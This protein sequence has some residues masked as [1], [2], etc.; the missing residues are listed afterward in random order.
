V[1]DTDQPPRRPD[2]IA[3][4]TGRRRIGV[5]GGSFDPIHEGH[6]R[7]AE[8][9]R[10][11]L[12]LE[13]VLLVPAGSQPL[14]GGHAPA[15]HRLAMVRLAV[16]GRDG[17]EVSDAEVA[18]PGTSYTVDTVRE[19]SKAL[20]AD[21]ELCLLIGTDA[22]RDLP[23]W[24]DVQEIFSHA[25]PVVL[26]RPGDGP[27]DW[28]DLAGRLTAGLAGRLRDSTVCL[29]RPVDVSS[30]EVRRRLAAGEPVSG[31]VPTAVEGYIRRHGLYG[32]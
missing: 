16:E 17:L 9:A 3:G 19:I 25:R 5:F 10:V 11:A 20:G 29:K 27:V 2:D 6:L 26:Q 7:A 1:P 30:T 4:A 8:D 28:D 22:V 32:I 15:D 12:G 23:D 24:R 18:R 13:R 31:L 21:V 14:K